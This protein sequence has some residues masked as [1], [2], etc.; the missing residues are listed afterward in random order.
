MQTQQATGNT[1]SNQSTTL[2][3]FEKHHIHGQLPKQLHNSHKNISTYHSTYLVTTWTH[4]RRT[5]L[6]WTNPIT[7][8]HPL[9]AHIAPTTLTTITRVIHNRGQQSCHGLPYSR[10]CHR[11]IIT[12]LACVGCHQV[13]TRRRIP[14]LLGC[15]TVV[16][17][18]LTWRLALLGAEKALGVLG[19][20]HSLLAVAFFA[21]SR[22]L[23]TNRQNPLGFPV[24]L[25]RPS[26]PSSIS[27]NVEKNSESLFGSIS[28]DTL[29]TSSHWCCGSFDGPRR[30]Q[31]ARRH[32]A[33]DQLLR[34]LQGLPGP[35]AVL[36]QNESVALG[37]PRDLV[38]DNLAVLDF[39]IL[40][41][42]GGDGL[43]TGLPAKPVDEN[44][45]V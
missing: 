7:S 24:C 35:L 14:S 37:F 6:M 12:H 5:T 41:K 29:L 21:L 45:T 19:P 15:V 4:V 25:S 26:G 38:F 40:A 11:R 33:L 32:P 22:D 1:K 34:L 20:I 39:T 17:L 23:Y 18:V 9:L 28:G 13:P 31:L 3:I 10:R 36:E 8:L 30:G 27:P 43:V 16:P 44:L 2:K 42:R